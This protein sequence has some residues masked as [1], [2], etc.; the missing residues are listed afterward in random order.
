MEEN[1]AVAEKRGNH[2]LDV[3]ERETAEQT[4]H[5]ERVAEGKSA[6]GRTFEQELAMEQGDLHGMMR[7]SDT[8]MA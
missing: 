3:R 8:W 4:A 6:F 7:W 1:L 5:A 2:L